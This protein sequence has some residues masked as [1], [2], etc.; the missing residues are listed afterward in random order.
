MKMMLCALPALALSLA[1]PAAASPDPTA[2][3]GALAVVG[4]NGP[5]WGT[6]TG[7]ATGSLSASV[8]LTKSADAASGASGSGMAAVELMGGTLHASSTATGV[9]DDTCLYCQEVNVSSTAIMWDTVDWFTIGGERTA[10]TLVPLDINIDGAMTGVAYARVKAYF[11][12]NPNYD[13]DSIP[14]IDVTN[15]RTD[16]LDNIFV[17]LTNDSMYVFVMLQTVAS[18][19]AGMFSE[20][21]FS[22]TLHLNWHIPDGVVAQTASGI[23]LHQADDAVPEP[24]SWALMIIGFFGAGGMMR[25]TKRLTFA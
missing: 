22:N 11:G 24:A 15:G 25:R 1:S 21:D 20:A 5:V 9:F 8:N 3:Y 4:M 19:G 18:A 10:A 7:G 13:V 2:Q 23:P 16:I 6:K 14:W 17:P 12:Y